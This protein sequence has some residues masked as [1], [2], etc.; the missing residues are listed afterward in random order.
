MKIKTSRFGEIEIREDQV[1]NF[2]E[3]ILGFSEFHD[4]TFIQEEGC[5]P[6]KILHSIDNPSLAFVVIDPMLVRPDYT[7]EISESELEFVEAKSTDDLRVYVIVTMAKKLEDTT[8]NLQGPLI[9]NTKKRICQQFVLYHDEYSTKES[10]M[11][12]DKVGQKGR[13]ATSQAS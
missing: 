4:Y 8:M 3:G 13:T 9:V 5:E 10:L 7:V 2:P 11:M 1:F 6:F 12:T